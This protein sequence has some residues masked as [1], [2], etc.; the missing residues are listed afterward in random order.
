MDILLE[1]IINNSNLSALTENPEDQKFITL[2]RIADD[3]KYSNQKVIQIKIL[4]NSNFPIKVNSV[5][6][7]DFTIDTTSNK[8]I[9]ILENPWTQSG[10]SKYIKHFRPT[11]RSTFLLSRDQNQNSFDKKY[12]YLE[13]SIVS[14]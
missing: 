2:E 4:N 7:S 5:I 13:N 14:E 12:G 1:Q 11:K 9:S 10:H 3:N 8:I 6:V